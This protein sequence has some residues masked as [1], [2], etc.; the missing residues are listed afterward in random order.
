MQANSWY[1]MVARLALLLGANVTG[2]SAAEIAPSTFIVGGN[3]PAATSNCVQE[4]EAVPCQ[5]VSASSQTV[6]VAAHG[7]GRHTQAVG[8]WDN[9][10][11]DQANGRGWPVPFDST[12]LANVSGD[13]WSTFS[14]SNDLV[15]MSFIGRR[16]NGRSCFALA[17][18]SP[19]NLALDPPVW[20]RPA[21][22]AVNLPSDLPRMLFDDASRTLWLVAKNAGTRINAFKNCRSFPGDSTCQQTAQIGPLS[23]DTVKFGISINPCTRNLILV[24]RDKSD[25]TRSAGIRMQFFAS[26]GGKAGVTFLVRKDHQWGTNAGCRPGV[27]RR[28]NQGTATCGAPTATT[29]LRMNGMPS[30][31]AKFDPATNKC[32]AAVAYDAFFGSWI[33]SRLDI[34]DITDEANP[35]L[36]RSWISTDRNF[37]F[38]H[39]LSYVTV[40]ALT[41]DIGWFW[42]S[43]N[44]GACN[45][46]FEGAVDSDLGLSNMSALGKFDGTFPAIHFSNP[47]GIN[48]YNQGVVGGSAGGFLYPAWGASVCTTASCGIPCSVTGSTCTRWN[49]AAKITRIKPSSADDPEKPTPGACKTGERCCRPA[50]DGGCFSCI[51]ASASCP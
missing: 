3:A 30:V 29:C 51:P 19:S 22:C 41:N 48:D 31:A 14:A 5:A 33:K 4:F 17:G 7:R 11:V 2:A 15:Y 34:V 46:G 49:L 44:R 50:P 37:T 10:D 26:S 16:P 27:V 1:A 32:Y 13:A 21:T 12:V 39:Y 25:A 38:N 24:D 47:S 36:A 43:D 28:C 6:L 8:G 9:W 42:I 35:R 23:P 45:V 18:S 40:N 20:T